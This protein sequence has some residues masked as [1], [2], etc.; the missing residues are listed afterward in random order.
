MPPSGT[1]SGL[2]P[3]LQTGKRLEPERNGGHL[4]G[5]SMRRDMGAGLTQSI[6]HHFRFLFATRF[7]STVG[8]LSP[9][10]RFLIVL[11]HAHVLRVPQ[12]S[13][14]RPLHKLELR[15]QYGLQA[16]GTPPSLRP[17]SGQLGTA[18][19]NEC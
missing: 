9:A 5:P 16:T 1:P 7:D 13:I 10:R 8:G 12:M 6:T 3:L 4:R 11:T 15:Y 14:A 17:I 19:A 2:T 18:K